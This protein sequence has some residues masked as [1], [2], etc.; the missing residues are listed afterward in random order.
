[1]CQNVNV[2]KRLLKCTHDS[3]GAIKPIF[4]CEACAKDNKTVDCEDCTKNKTLGKLEL[5][6]HKCEMCSEEKNTCL[7]REQGDAP[8]NPKD[9]PNID[10]QPVLCYEC[11]QGDV[12]V[13]G[14]KMTRKVKP[15]YNL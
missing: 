10:Y 4:M 14:T 1:M 9:D 8:R 11:A 7:R 3:C 2:K 13:K 6:K 5:H 12:P 15:G